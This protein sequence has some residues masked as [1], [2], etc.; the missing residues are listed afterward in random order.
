MISS[1]CGNVSVQTSSCLK[2]PALTHISTTLQGKQRAL[3]HGH[4]R[5]T[6]YRHDLVSFFIQKTVFGRS[7][8]D[9][10]SV[11]TMGN[12]NSYLL[13][14]RCSG[15]WERTPSHW[16]YS[17]KQDSHKQ[18]IAGCKET[19]HLWIV[20]LYATGHFVQISQFYINF[21]KLLLVLPHFSCVS[22]SW[23]LRQVFH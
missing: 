20:A 16:G 9:T 4:W 22:P 21:S 23:S 18:H 19:T 10:K 11:L 14:W 13:S 1:K 12:L 7:M 6:W 15:N 8:G 3:H 17:A 5:V 2:A